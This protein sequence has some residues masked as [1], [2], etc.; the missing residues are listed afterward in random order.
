MNS[1][2]HFAYGSLGEWFYEYLAGIRRDPASPG[3]KHFLIAPRPAGDLQWAEA[4]Y[5]SPYGKIHS[6]WDKAADRF[7]LKCTVPGQ[8]HRP[9][10]F[11]PERQNRP[12]HQRIRQAD[13]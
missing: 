9:G 2:N 8:Q 11:T 13:L 3:F 12:G 7:T 6:R 5:L 1:R 10:P 4:S